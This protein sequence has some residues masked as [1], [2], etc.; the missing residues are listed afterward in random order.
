M[1]VT[2]WNEANGENMMTLT[3]KRGT[4][5]DGEPFHVLVGFKMLSPKELPP[6]YVHATDIVRCYC[7]PPYMKGVVGF[8]IADKNEYNTYMIGKIFDTS[9]L[10]RVIGQ[11]REAGNNLHEINKALRKDNM[12]EWS[13][14]I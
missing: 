4:W 13:L 9:T 12:M 2:R 10:N 1:G 11:L 3:F 6:S 5:K 7:N 8:T 14:T